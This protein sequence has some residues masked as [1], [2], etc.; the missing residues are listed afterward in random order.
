MLRSL[1][2]HLLIKAASLAP[3]APSVLHKENAVLKCTALLCSQTGG[4]LLSHSSLP[5]GAMLP[6]GSL[7]YGII[8]VGENL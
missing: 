8:K 1:H 5:L 4:V 3:S 6:S 2:K 7:P